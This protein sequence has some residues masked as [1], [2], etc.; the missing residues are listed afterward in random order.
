MILKSFGYIIISFKLKSLVEES[1][2]PEQCRTFQNALSACLCVRLLMKIGND[3]N[4]MSDLMLR[5]FDC[6]SN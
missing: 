3:Q 2:I 5:K 1:D 4:S 6:F